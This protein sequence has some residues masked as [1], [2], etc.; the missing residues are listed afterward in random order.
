MIVRTSVAV[1]STGPRTT[2]NEASE[3]NVEAFLLMFDNGI[4]SGKMNEGNTASS[5]GNLNEK[6]RVSYVATFIRPWSQSVKNLNYKFVCTCLNNQY[7]KI[8]NCN[9]LISVPVNAHVDTKF[10]GVTNLSGKLEW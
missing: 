4:M 10:G 5:F 9:K 2:V 3:V 1:E 6:V 8:V 7:A